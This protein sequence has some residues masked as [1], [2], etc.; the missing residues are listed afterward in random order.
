MLIHKLLSILRR[1]RRFWSKKMIILKIK[2]SGHTIDLPGMHGIKTPTEVNVSKMNIDLVVSILRKNGIQKF[3]IIG[4]EKNN[5]EQ[6]IEPIIK[7]VD[8]IKEIYVNEKDYELH[9]KVNNIENLLADF[10]KDFKNSPVVENVIKKKPKE[11]DE[12]VDFIPTIDISGLT[13]KGTISQTT[14]K[15]ND[16]DN[17]IEKSAKLLTSLTKNN[18]KEKQGK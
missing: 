17:N 14:S 12:K 3:E 9:N 15:T 5:E 1:I 16:D 8:I 13:S 7:K 2:D 11:V 10:M 4:Q 6:K 18:L